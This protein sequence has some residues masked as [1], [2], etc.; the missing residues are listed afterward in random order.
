MEIGPI[1]LLVEKSHK[2]NVRRSKIWCKRHDLD[3]F[4]AHGFD[5]VCWRGHQWPWPTNERKWKWSSAWTSYVS[6]SC[7][8]LMGL[9]IRANITSQEA[10]LNLLIAT[11]PNVETTNIFTNGGYR[12]KV[13]FFAFKSNKRVGGTGGWLHDFVWWGRK[14]S[15]SP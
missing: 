3:T 13:P 5:R 15:S 1:Q 9:F 12:W 10:S 4:Q 6:F 2:V 8:W 14:E 11:A 7:R